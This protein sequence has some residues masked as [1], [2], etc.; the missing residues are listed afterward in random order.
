MIKKYSNYPKFPIFSS[1]DKYRPLV[2]T[3]EPLNFEILRENQN[4]FIVIQIQ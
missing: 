3:A 1:G 2:E 4:N